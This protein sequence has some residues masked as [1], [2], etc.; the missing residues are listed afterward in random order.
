MSLQQKNPFQELWE[1]L[2]APIRN[3][4][5]IALVLFFGWLVLID[6][7]GPLTQWKLSQGVKELEQDKAYYKQKIEEAR[8]KERVL[9]EEKERFAREEY[10]LQKEN[11]DVFIIEDKRNQ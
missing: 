5:F 7:A 2:P 8:E 3:R 9:S 11:E 6:K 1:Q 10:Y 4:Y